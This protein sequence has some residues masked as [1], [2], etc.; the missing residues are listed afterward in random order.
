M[1]GTKQRTE[2]GGQIRNSK[3]EDPAFVPRPRDYGAQAKQIQITRTKANAEL[4]FA[5]ASACKHDY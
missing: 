4:A 2:D 5:E 1:T 3:S